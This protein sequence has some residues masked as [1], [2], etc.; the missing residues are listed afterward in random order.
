MRACAPALAWTA[1]QDCVR[2]VSPCCH[3]APE[4]GGAGQR[5]GPAWRRRTVSAV[6]CLSALLA[7]GCEGAPSADATPP[8]AWVDGSGSVDGAAGRAAP[9]AGA[10]PWRATPKGP[11]GGDD[12]ASSGDAA[13]TADSSDDAG[14]QRHGGSHDGGTQ[15]GGDGSTGESDGSTGEGDGST[16]ESDGSTGESDGAA[17]L[18]GEAGATGDAASDAQG[19]AQG[20]GDAQQAKVCFVGGPPGPDD[21]VADVPQPDVSSCPAA[22]YWATQTTPASVQVTLGDNTPLGGFVPWA[23]APWVPIVHGPQGGI[24][25]ELS[26]RATPKQALSGATALFQLSAF[27]NIGCNKA[28]SPSLAPVQLYANATGGFG[29]PGKGAKSAKGGQ[30]LLVIL[31]V[32]S[33]Q[34]KLYCGVWLDLHVMARHK[35]SG[36]W[37]FTHHRVRLYD[38]K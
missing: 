33:A 11:D 20:D 14:P 27:A 30:T 8:G 18:D 32:S 21:L 23:K 17:T 3:R 15:V 19:D 4:R 16:G 24:H 31:P 2:R 13:G 36:A 22:T 34:S 35:A 25:V 12:D 26:V 37:G 9:D 5:R 28:S 7:W 29:P 6:A 1:T 38:T 10:A